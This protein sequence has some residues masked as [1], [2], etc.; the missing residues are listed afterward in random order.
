[1]IR[2]AIHKPSPVRHTEGVDA[3]RVVADDVHLRAARAR[4]DKEARRHLPERDFH[5]WPEHAVCALGSY[6]LEPEEM[7]RDNT[8]EK[9][10]ALSTRG[11]PR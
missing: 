6:G 8:H 5:R 9:A 1:M 7:H 3:R 10:V 4:E 11:F 2:G